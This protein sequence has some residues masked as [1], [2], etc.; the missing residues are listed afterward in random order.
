[1]REIEAYSPKP[2]SPFSC[3]Y[4][5]ACPFSRVKPVFVCTLHIPVKLGWVAMKACGLPNAYWHTNVSILYVYLYTFMRIC[6]QLGVHVC[7][8]IYIC[9]YVCMYVSLYVFVCFYV[10]VCVYVFPHVCT[11]RFA[12]QSLS[13]KV[14]IRNRRW[15][16]TLMVGWWHVDSLGR[17]SSPPSLFLELKQCL[18]AGTHRKVAHLQPR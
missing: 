18:A 5:A 13:F 12:L 3:M 16:R 4:N 6:M 7:M 11:I 1:M 17:H 10:C 2:I 15:A 14:Q 9:L 8:Y